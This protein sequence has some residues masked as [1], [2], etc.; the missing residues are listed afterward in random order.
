MFVFK[1]SYLRQSLQLLDSCS[2]E[3][4][5]VAFELTKA[6]FAFDAALLLGDNNITLSKVAGVDLSND[7]EMRGHGG[8]IGLR[9]ELDDVLARNDLI[10]GL[11]CRDRSSTGKERCDSSRNGYC[12]SKELHT[13]QGQRRRRS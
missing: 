9:L 13:E 6:K 3:G 11:A 7:V 12:A 4:S 8:N 2:I 10:S 5:R 1:I